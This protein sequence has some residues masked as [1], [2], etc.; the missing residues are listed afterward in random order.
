MHGNLD[1]K[2]KKHLQIEFNKRK[3]AECDNCKGNPNFQGILNWIIQELHYYCRKQHK[4]IENSQI[5][6]ENVIFLC[7]SL[8]LLQLALPSPSSL[9]EFFQSLD[10]VLLKFQML[11]VIICAIYSFA[12]WFE[13]GFLQVK[14]S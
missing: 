9:A 2:Q 10:T 13:N 5:F 12:F 7:P 6:E 3:K 11:Q 8:C 1:D 4:Y 14:P